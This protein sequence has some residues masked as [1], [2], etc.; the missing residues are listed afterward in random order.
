[1]K[2]PDTLTDIAAVQLHRRGR[3]HVWYPVVKTMEPG[4]RVVVEGATHWFLWDKVK[5]V[6]EEL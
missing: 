2:R 3:S 6:K 1:M 5:A 4:V